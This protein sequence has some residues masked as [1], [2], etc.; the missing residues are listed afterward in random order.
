MMLNEAAL[1]WMNDLSAQ[2]I[3]MTDADL[4]VRG[5]NHWLETR[6]GRSAADMIGRSL[7]EVYPDLVERGLDRYYRNALAG[8]VEILS[9]RFHRY[10]LP[11][12][13]HVDDTSFSQM[14]QSA[15]I[16]PLIEGDR[17][18]GTITIID[19]VTERIA[20]EEQL[21]QLLNRE[22]AAR[23]DAETAN[24]TKDEFLA[25]VSHELRTPLNAIAGWV[26]VLRRRN[27]DADT[28]T[29]GL[30]TI[31][32]NVKM[33]TKIIEDI[34][35]VSR[36]ITGKLR[37][38]I[39]PVNLAPVIE[40]ALDAVRLAAD[41]KGIQLQ[42]AL[43]PG[44]GFVSGDNNRLQQIVWNLV[45][46]AIKF[47]PKGGTVNVRLARV[48]SQAEIRVSDTGK[49]ISTEFLPFVFERFRQADSTSTRQHSGLGLG[50]AI[51]RHLVEM[52]GGAV[53]ATSGGDGQ[54]ATFTVRIP[55]LAVSGIEDLPLQSASPAPSDNAEH[56]FASVTD[57]ALK[58]IPR[59]N[60]IRV[61]VVDDDADAREMLEIMLVQFGADLKVSVSAKEALKA[62]DHWKPDVLV[63]D[64]EMPGEDG[65]FL[66]KQV[67]A[68]PPERGG[69]VP[70]VALTGY[71]RQEDRLRL[72]AAGYQE[73]LSKP[74]EM[75]Q[76]AEAIRSLSG[77]AERGH[78]TSVE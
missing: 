42:S 37:L 40:S 55:T 39:A 36:I 24:R 68:L 51:V 49:G 3:L 62:L 74:V 73:H 75:V 9:H 53:E 32:R 35:D 21:L 8:Q 12:P 34:L 46:N 17:I 54:G 70:A 14:Q 20:R 22:K 23:K 59:L 63:S 71:S 58:E 64:I 25:T 28:L 52:H 33:Q 41:A 56:L 2:G 48:E 60:G 65:Y 5:W 6:S 78:F 13:P 16:A 4:I 47:T 30:Q 15:R 10:L 19:D 1:R 61:L 72:L 69:K 38:D 67:R 29:H 11:L 76:L 18:I 57:A 43:D 26:Q 7:L 77:R 66:I 27:V 50:L 44:A 45:S 31:E